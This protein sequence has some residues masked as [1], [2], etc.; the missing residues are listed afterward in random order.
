M[1][2][3]GQ[4]N[5]V[6]RNAVAPDGSIR[7]VAPTT[8]EELEQDVSMHESS[9]SDGEDDDDEDDDDDSE[10]SALLELE[11]EQSRVDQDTC[12]KGPSCVQGKTCLCKQKSVKKLPGGQ[13]S[14]WKKTGKCK[15]RNGRK[16]WRITRKRKN[17]QKVRV[18]VRWTDPQATCFNTG[19]STGT[20]YYKGD[21]GGHVAGVASASA[22]QVLCQ[23]NKD[24]GV[25]VYQA[26]SKKCWKK[27]SLGTNCASSVNGAT[28]AAN[29]G[30]GW[31]S[32]PKSCQAGKAML[33]NGQMNLVRGNA[34]APDGS[35]PPATP[36][37]VEELE[38]ESSEIDGEDDDDE[39]DDDDSED[40][41]SEDS[42]LLE[43]EDE[44]SRVDQ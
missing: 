1:L 9:E 16:A 12:T 14:P 38:Q 13:Y 4:T 7:P 8:V 18:K 22:C 39:D 15:C 6:Q 23:L 28:E 30:S 35:I 40:D 31:T 32:G 43:L 36:T 3:N 10:D 24:C 19:P 42:A 29:L 5:L 37:S 20:G 41:D 2:D 21:I 33:D 34:V 26:S 44:Q 17:G 25:F 27:C 11:D